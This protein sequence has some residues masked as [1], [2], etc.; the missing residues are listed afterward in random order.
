MH[1]SSCDDQKVK[2][3]RCCL[4]FDHTC[5]GVDADY[6]SHEDGCVFLAAQNVPNRPSDIGRRKRS[7]C[8]PVKQWLKT[9]IVVTIDQ[10]DLD[11]RTAQPFRCLKS[12]ETSPND[13]YSR[14]LRHGA[15]LSGV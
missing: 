14:T 13:N 15:R 5:L 1:C 12:S 3:E 9:M 7:S 6:F 2:G 4:R 10:R 8:Y 11:R